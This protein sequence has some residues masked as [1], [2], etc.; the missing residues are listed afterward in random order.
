MITGM[1]NGKALKNQLAIETGRLR[2]LINDPVK[3]IGT[4][5]VL[6]ILHT[7]SG[8]RKVCHGLLSGVG[9]LGLLLLV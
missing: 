3:A 2:N 1:T 6:Q 8:L 9:T 4:K 7:H 5:K